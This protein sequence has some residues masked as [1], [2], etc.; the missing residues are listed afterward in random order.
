MNASLFTAHT[1]QIGFGSL[2]A[3]D[4]RRHADHGAV[5]RDISVDERIRAD[6]HVVAHPDSARHHG[7]RPEIDP[8]PDLRHSPMLASTRYPHR[9]SLRQAAV[10]PNPSLGMQDPATAVREMQ[11]RTDYG[12]ARETDGG[13]NFH[14]FVCH[15]ED[16]MR[17]TLENFGQWPPVYRGV[18]PVNQRSPQARLQQHQLE[19]VFPG[20]STV[21]PDVA[22]KIGSPSHAVG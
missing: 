19:P 21:P 1:L 20:I 15:S 6:E 8:I 14:N 11:A 16:Q 7:V 13:H 2:L 5:R 3:D 4:A 12:R 10:A 9:H 18:D 17:W 22:R